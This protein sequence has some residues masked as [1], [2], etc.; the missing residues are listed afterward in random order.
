MRQRQEYHGG[1]IFWS[2]RKMAKGKARERTNKRP[3]EEEKLQKVQTKQLQ[4]AN[5][6]YYKKLRGEACGDSSKA[7]VRRR[8]QKRRLLRQLGR[9]S[10]TLRSLSTLP[11]WVSAKLQLQLLERQSDRSVLVVL[12]HL[13]K[14]YLLSR[15]RSPAA[16]ALSSYQLGT[17]NLSCPNC[18]L[19][20]MY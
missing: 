18:S 12:Q 8:R 1:A 6:L 3:A 4:A 20:L 7:S 17:H 16:A 9:R 14:S 13:L 10:K 15:P 5:A 19:Y 2:P 11:K